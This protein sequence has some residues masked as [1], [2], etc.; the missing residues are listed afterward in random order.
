MRS[1]VVFIENI[2]L[3]DSFVQRLSSYLKD[4]DLLSVLYRLP[5]VKSEAMPLIGDLRELRL[6]K[7]KRQLVSWYEQNKIPALK[8]NPFVF[9]EGITAENIRISLNG[10]QRFLI[11]YEKEQ[12]MDLKKMFK[13]VLADREVEFKELDI[14]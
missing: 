12:L 10:D 11:L 5:K 2:A 3:T 4:N 8:F 14:F 7:A 13:D 6:K 9:D 1:V